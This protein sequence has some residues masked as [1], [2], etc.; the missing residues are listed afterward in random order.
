M[1]TH[2]AIRHPHFERFNPC[3]ESGFSLLEAVLALAVFSFAVVSLVKALNEISLATSESA[4]T[5]EI[6]EQLR[7][8]LTEVLYNPNIEAG[9]A[10]TGPDEL[11]LWYQSVVEPVDDLQNFA[12]STL[13]N[14]YR[15]EI[16]AVRKTGGGREEIVDQAE[17]LRYGP[18]YELEK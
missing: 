6:S 5:L 10:E 11:G 18:L 8:Y 4:E 16:R 12:G 9:Q 13:A 2:R 1:K 14:L 17:T 15:V 7:S 3:S